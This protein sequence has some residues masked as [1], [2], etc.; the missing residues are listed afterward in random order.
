MKAISGIVPS[1]IAA[2]PANTPVAAV[3]KV[4]ISNADKERLAIIIE[5]VIAA[6][7]YG[8][9]HMTNERRIAIYDNWVEVL[10]AFRSTLTDDL[11]KL[12]INRIVALSP[13][14][15]PSPYEFISYCLITNFPT[16]A[17]I[18]DYF[19]DGVSS[20]E[21]TDHYFVQYMAEQLSVT[22]PALNNRDRKNERVRERFQR[23]L[24]DLIEGRVG[25]WKAHKDEVAAKKA[26]HTQAT[27]TDNSAIQ[28]YHFLVKTMGVEAAEF[29]RAEY[30]KRLNVSVNVEKGSIIGNKDATISGRSGSKVKLTQPQSHLLVMLSR[31]GIDN[32]PNTLLELAKATLTQLRLH[33]EY[34]PSVNLLEQ[35]I[36]RWSKNDNSHPA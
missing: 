27:S 32:T 7:R 20:Q 3:A 1:S 31:D 29:Y 4:M 18:E 2:K 13:K 12:G 28:Y 16:Y 6:S 14:D 17:Q 34:M 19:V 9:M 22:L 33:V 8:T 26:K 30:E 25:K 24:F 35:Y 23:S 10:W 36:K 21:V 11:V 15:I 5:R